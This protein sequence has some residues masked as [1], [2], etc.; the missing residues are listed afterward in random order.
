M[1]PTFHTLIYS[2]PR[3]DVDELS[4]VRFQLGN[5]LG[6]DFVLQSDTDPS[7]INKIIL[8]KINMKVP[9]KGEVVMRLIDLARERNI[10]FQPGGESR[11]ELADYCL[12]K[13]IPVREN[14]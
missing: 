3:I 9:E 14:Y 10:N 12:R 4:E 8:D 13:E 2:A 11:A 6:K 7:S 5:L 1:H